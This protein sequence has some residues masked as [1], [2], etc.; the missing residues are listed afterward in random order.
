MDRITSRTNP[1]IQRARSLRESKY[2]KQ[3]GCHFVEGDKLVR[4]ALSSGVELETVFVREG[5]AGPV[6]FPCETVLVTD[7][8]MDALSTA[9]TPQSLCAVAKTP[10]LAL[11][12]AFSGTVLLLEDV[13]DPGN[14]GTMIRTAAAFGFDGVLLL[15]GCADPWGPKAVRASMGAVFRLPVWEREDAEETLR[16]LQEAGLPLYAAALREDAV[17]AGGQSFPPELVLAIGNE[18]HG[19]SRRVLDLA[20]TVL[21]IPMEPG[22]ES[23]NA[24]AAAAVLMWEVYRE[25]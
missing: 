8:V 15:G 19:L 16:E 1:R 4:E 14:V 6:D 20:D 24:A 25:R 21:R 23:L 3:T 7:G 17:P 2:R 22:A 11:P 12:D 18:G 5:Y 9:G 13:Q 10:D